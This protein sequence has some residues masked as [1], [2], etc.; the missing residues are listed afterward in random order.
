MKFQTLDGSL[1]IW[2]ILI[3]ISFSSCNLICDKSDQITPAPADEEDQEIPEEDAV[4]RICHETCEERDTFNM[5][6]SCRGA[7]RL[8]HKACAYRWFGIKG[9]SFC[10][11]CRREVQNLPVTL[12]RVQ[13][14]SQTGDRNQN[15]RDSIR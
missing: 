14:V 15:Q 12:L 7:L 13:N 1:H 11:V 10:D 2:W 6:C 5:G 3:C 9:N 8:V 4:C